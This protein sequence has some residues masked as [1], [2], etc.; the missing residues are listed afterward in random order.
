MKIKVFVRYNGFPLSN[1][2][3]LLLIHFCNSCFYCYSLLIFAREIIIY[4]FVVIDLF[5]FFCLDYMSVCCYIEDDDGSKPYKWGEKT[6]ILGYFYINM[7]VGVCYPVALYCELLFQFYERFCL[8][9]GDKGVTIGKPFTF[10]SR[11]YF[12]SPP[13]SRQ[14]YPQQLLFTT[15]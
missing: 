13:M 5:F 9:C 6:I 7:C 3:F 12:P 11:W 10:D 8:F 4:I 15:G 1:L 2:Q 14:F